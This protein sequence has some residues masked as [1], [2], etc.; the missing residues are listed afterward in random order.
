[1]FV[2]TAVPDTSDSIT[3]TWQ[4]PADNGGSAITGYELEVWD[5]A[6]RRLGE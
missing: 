3:V 5:S 2:A 1:M 4:R 6:N